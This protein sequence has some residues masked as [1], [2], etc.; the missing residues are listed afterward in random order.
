M[1]GFTNF[2]VKK[3][4]W[5]L[6]V[7]ILLLIPSIFGYLSTYVNYDILTYL[8]ENLE[9][10]I[11][12]KY[13]ENDFK[14]A[15]TAMITVENMPTKD[16]LKLKEDLSG[17]KGVD[18]VIW[19]DDIMPV[20]VPKE[21][22][23]ADIQK[24]FYND[25]GATLLIVKFSDT[26]ASKSTMDA[27]G[28]IKKVMRSDCFVGGMSAIIQD[29]KILADKEMP[30]YVLIA[31]ALSILVL[32][33]GLTSTAVPFIFMIGMIFPI[34]YNFGTNV[35]LGQVSYITQSLATV[36]QL[37]VTMDFSIFLL[38][39]YEEEKQK[40]P[41]KDTAMQMAIKN[42]MTSI[43]GSSLTTIAGFLAMCAMSLTLGRDIGLVMAKGV[44]LGVI[45]TITI[46]PSL[47]MTF[48]KVIHKYSHR[49]IIPRLNRS[50]YFIV[51]HYKIILAVFV[52]A[53]IPF[54]IAQSKTSVYYTLI[55]SLPKNLVSIQGT[56]QLKK[57]FNMTT[58]HF[59]IVDENLSNEQVNEMSGQIEQLDGIEQV[60]SYEKFVGGG[61]PLDFIP[62]DV[63]DIFNQGGKK[64]IL[65]NSSFKAASN[66]QN[67]QID[68]MNQIIKKYDSSAVITGEGA[69]TKD[70]VEIADT[71]FANVSIT[72]ILMVFLIIC[73]VFK[74]ASIPVLLVAA[75]ES[76]IMINM[77]IPYFQGIQLP[78]I[79]SIVVGTIQ[80]GAT[81][82]YAILM[83]TRFKEEL[84]NGLNTKEA[85]RVS[86]ENCSQSILS[87][88]LTFFAAT[89]GVAMIS[90]IELIK[91]L[92][93]LISR[94]AVISMFV[95]L[96]ILPAFMIIFSKVIQKTTF[97]WIKR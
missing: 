81:V 1:D 38:H 10:I 47:I 48:D 79:S 18:K 73:I 88:G 17:I 20:S 68:Q 44:F 62:Q 42:T 92:C 97:H 31:V 89:I 87:S 93:L 27:I 54:F 21:M 5:I 56:D 12:E 16:T 43:S 90:K 57:D 33:A 83:M 85:V 94:G 7:A 24:F 80:L 22:L 71:D 39:R 78:F 60:L 28:Q 66:E 74:S 11:G 46:L 86:I 26:S 29:T 53:F 30:F 25:S 32:M 37:G 35:L 95:I 45:C 59:I 70:L 72:S 55:D 19:T 96:F 23:P 84:N 52:I 13:L 6:A 8:P 69:M 14:T 36:L 50:S 77:G 40:Q 4:K 76:A 49:T 51:K 3:R 91:S 82:D 63:K 67:A 2:I 61:V 64:M 41:D 15:S 9:S 34:V 58:T 75:I 65:A